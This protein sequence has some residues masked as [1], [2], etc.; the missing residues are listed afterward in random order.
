MRIDVPTENLDEAVRIA[1]ETGYDL[2]GLRFLPAA[3]QGLVLDPIV[4]TANRA[5]SA[6]ALTGS[7]VDVL[8]GT[9]MEADGRPFV[10][11]Q[12]RDLPGV[13][14]LDRLRTARAQIRLIR[15]AFRQPDWLDEVTAAVVTATL[16]AQAALLPPDAW[17]P[18][19]GS[20]ARF[21]LSQMGNL[22]F[23]ALVLVSCVFL[24]VGAPQEPAPMEDEGFV[25]AIGSADAASTLDYVE[26]YTEEM[27]AVVEQ[28]PEINDFFLFNGGFGGMGGSNSAMGGFVMKPWSQRDRSTNQILQQ[29][30]QPKLAEITGLNIFAL[31]PPSLPSDGGDGGGEFL[32]GG[33]G[34]LEQLNELADQ[35]V[36]RAQES[37]RFIFLDKDLKID[38]PR[39]EV[40]ID[41]DKAALLGIDMRTLAADMR[42]DNLPP[43]PSVTL[44]GRPLPGSWPKPGDAPRP[45]RWGRCRRR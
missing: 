9:A 16:S 41:R 39:V 28:I 40:Q 8:D 3:A 44:A 12:L 24:Y 31:V 27:T 11:Q 25:F 42:R 22:M 38:K 4:L 26:R 18:Y 14:G 15:Q 35:L 13:T 6:P 32:I 45:A 21:A 37:R 20:V 23:G 19:G 43:A 1:A 30:L 2:V 29:D 5:P 36:A 7:S 17:R 33:I 34:S 10:L